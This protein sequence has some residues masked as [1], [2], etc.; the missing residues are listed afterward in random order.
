MARTRR[1]DS[2]APAGAAGPLRLAS[3]ADTARRLKPFRHV[4][5]G[6]ICGTETVGFPTPQG[7]SPNELVVDASEGFI[8]LWAADTILRWRFQPQA[9]MAFEDPTA[10]RAALRQLFGDALLLWGEAA[11]VRFAERED[12]WD[13]EISVRRQDDC[14]GGGCVLASA[15]FP[16][17]GRHELVI[18]P[19][20]L[21][22]PRAEQLETLAHEV[23][24][25]FG[26]RH[27]FAKVS[28]TAWPS[29]IFGEHKPFS[30]MNYGANSTMT[31]TDRRDLKELYRLARSA[32]LTHIN[33][34]PIRLVR[35]FSATIQEPFTVGALRRVA[36]AA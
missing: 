21:Q 24:H 31:D 4:H 18:Y 13:F 27:F 19:K 29:E 12:A 15:F 35:A 8:P 26:L 1:D 30:I 14:D 22:Q 10:A 28:E 33:G 32:A 25:V 9:M 2:K 23:G 3:A 36:T 6:V 7:R 20:M 5:H 17:G 11:P 16:D 34:T